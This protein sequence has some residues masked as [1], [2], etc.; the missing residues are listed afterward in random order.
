MDLC[1]ASKILRSKLR[2]ARL[3]AVLVDYIKSLFPKK[4]DKF[5]HPAVGLA[6][7]LHLSTDLFAYPQRPQPILRTR[8]CGQSLLDLS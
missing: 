1:L 8:P 3:T 6:L 5:N 7:P 4:R 2:N